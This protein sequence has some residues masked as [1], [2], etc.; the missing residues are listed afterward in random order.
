M[1]SLVKVFLNKP[2]QHLMLVDAGCYRNDVH[3][4]HVFCG[5]GGTK[6]PGKDSSK[7]KVPDMASA[8]FEPISTFE[9][10]TRWCACTSEKYSS[11]LILPVFFS[12]ALGAKIMR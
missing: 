11:P 7:I 9:F 8:A 2:H 10:S 4:I 12:S 1:A 3:F 5:V 6:V